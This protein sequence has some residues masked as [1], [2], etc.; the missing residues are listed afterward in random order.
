MTNPTLYQFVASGSR[1]TSGPIH[2][3]AKVITAEIPPRSWGVPGPGRSVHPGPG[4]R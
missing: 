2:D 3:Y 1:P 4:D